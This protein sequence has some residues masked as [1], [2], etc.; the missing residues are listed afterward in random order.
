[1]HIFILILGAVVAFLGGLSA[2]MDDTLR[3]RLWGLLVFTFGVLV[4]VV[5]L[6]GGAKVDKKNEAHSVVSAQED[7]TF[8][9]MRNPTVLEVDSTGYTITLCDTINGVSYV[10]DF[11]FASGDALK[12][13]VNKKGLRI[14]FKAFYAGFQLDKQKDEKEFRILQVG[15]IFLVM[16][17]IVGLIFNRFRN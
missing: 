11:D 10:K 6:M 4:V 12:P 8:L 16:A 2:V 14:D 15:V 17:T 7:K 5:N 1:M 9:L 13:Y 3:K